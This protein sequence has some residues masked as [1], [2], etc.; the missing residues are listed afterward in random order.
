MKKLNYFLILLFFLASCTSKNI[1]LNKMKVIVWDMAC[2]DELYIEKMHKD[3]TLIKKKENIRLYEQVFLVH[4]ISKDQFYS[5]Y[6]F[7]QE[8]A[9]QYKTLIDSVQAYGMRQRSVPN[10][11][12]PKS[13]S[14]N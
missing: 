14:L 6:K 3:S 8:H 10:N 12:I 7:Y 5:S 2:A 9:D 4:K 1:P 11:L 13:S